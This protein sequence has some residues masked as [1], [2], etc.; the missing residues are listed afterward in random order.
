MSLDTVMAKEPGY[1]SSIKTRVLA[2]FSIPRKSQASRHSERFNS[3]ERFKI[4]NVSPSFPIIY[5]P[6]IHNS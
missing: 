6:S 5:H 1:T 4:A 2:H 3:S